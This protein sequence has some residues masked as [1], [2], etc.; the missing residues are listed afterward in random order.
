MRRFVLDR[1]EDKSG[2]SG[3]GIVAEGCCFSDGTT[4]L[5][6][7]AAYHSTVVYDSI[8]DLEAIHGHQGAT[9]VRWLDR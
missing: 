5:R 2:L 8:Y 4:V 9:V 1:S 6:W 3:T 7:T